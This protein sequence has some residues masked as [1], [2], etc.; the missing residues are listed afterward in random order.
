MDWSP[1]SRRSASRREQNL[2]LIGAVVSGVVI[3]FGLLL[4]LISRVNP[5]QGT[6]LRGA[7]L[8]VVT[9]LWS[10]VRA[11]FDGAARL[12]GNIS[13][14]LGA[15]DKNR[16]LT[17]ELEDGRAKTQ[18]AVQLAVE[19][20][21]LRALLK[22]VEPRTA[23]VATARLAGASSGG[24]V[25]SAVISAGSAEGVRPGQ[26]VRAGSG[27][28]GR[29]LE[30]GSHAARVLLLTDPA[31]RVPVIVERT[32][33]PALANGANAPLMEIRDRIGDET[34]LRLGDRLV[35]SGDGGIFPPG[36]PVA[37]VVRIAEPT[38]A[39]PLA[40]AHGIGLVSIESAFLP[41]PPPPAEAATVPV[42]RE[43]GGG[44]KPVAAPPAALPTA[45]PAVATPAAAR[46][47]A[48]RPAA[49]PPMPAR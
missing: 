28:I 39:R 37:V 27:L 24:A 32:G 10:V 25:R 48:A 29:T 47:A 45:T 21:Q 18:R 11:P 22:V 19:N 41:V 40:D 26:P 34:P 1:P 38:L 12:N 49:A 5:D 14:Y 43:A 4:L 7:A 36:V 42:P 9:P 6:R 44:R 35:T 2:A 30:V 31:S 3:A 15:V 17:A 8:D 23:L 20:R 46:P 33:Q 16:A 13:D